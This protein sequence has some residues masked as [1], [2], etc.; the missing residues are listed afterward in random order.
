LPLFHSAD[1]SQLCNVESSQESGRS[2]AVVFTAVIVAMIVGWIFKFFESWMELP[3]NPD[4]DTLRSEQ[5]SLI[6]DPSSKEATKE[7]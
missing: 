1:P 5:P 2:A 3:S 4:P 6:S 7:R